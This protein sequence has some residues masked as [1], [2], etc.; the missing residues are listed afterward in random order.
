[1]TDAE[2][3]QHAQTMALKAVVM[4]LIDFQPDRKSLGDRVEFFGQFLMAQF[5]NSANVP[6]GYVDQ[7]QTVMAELETRCRLP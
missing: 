2:I 5:L 6:D 1:M 7:F 4:A 3:S